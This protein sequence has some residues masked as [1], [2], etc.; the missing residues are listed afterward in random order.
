MTNTWNRPKIKIAKTTGEWVWDIIGIVIYLSSVF[1]LIFVWNT[2]P[3]EVPAHYNAA[4]EVDRWGA[5]TELLIL[6]AI[7]L[8]TFIMMQVFERFPEIHNYPSRINETNAERFYLHS[9]KMLNQLK[10]IC[11]IIFALILVESVSTALGWWDGFGIW[12][13]PLILGGTFIPIIIGLIK[14][15]KIK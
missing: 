11:L 9:R 5:K 14:Q 3:D 15:S 4:G 8:F 7:G 1:F 13:M 10:N 2:L 12:F 6:P